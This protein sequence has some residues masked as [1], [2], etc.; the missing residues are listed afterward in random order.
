MPGISCLADKVLTLFLLHIACR[1]IGSGAAADRA[2]ACRVAECL[3][4]GGCGVCG[5]PCCCSTRS[6]CEQPPLQKL[7]EAVAAGHAH[8]HAAHSLAISEYISE[9]PARFP[10]Q[11]NASSLAFNATEPGF[12][13]ADVAP[14]LQGDFGGAYP[15]AAASP[16]V[17]LV[18]GSAAGGET[19]QQ[20]IAN[21]SS[22]AVRSTKP[23]S[24]RRLSCVVR[25]TQPGQQHDSW[26]P[27][28][29]TADH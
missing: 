2:G 25:F 9:M 29:G 15:A 23:G 3:S 11:A 16:L 5:A 6:R 18:N 19:L 20:L 27:D 13:P 21:I 17:S 26:W 8:Q 12:S 14:L 24:G 10:I 1:A 7:S 28:A 4:S 22:G